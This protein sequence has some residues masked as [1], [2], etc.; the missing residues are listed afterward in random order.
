MRACARRE[1]PRVPIERTGGRGLVRRPIELY[2]PR[3]RITENSQRTWMSSTGNTLLM[4]ISTRAIGAT[5]CLTTLCMA[6]TGSAPTYTLIVGPRTQLGPLAGVP[7]NLRYTPISG[8][9]GDLNADGA[10]DIILGINGAPPAVYFNNRT[11]DP[12]QNVS[13]VFAAPPPGASQAGISWGAVVIAD[14]NGD[15]RPDLAIGG[16]NAPNMI[17]LNDGTATPFNGVSGIAIGTQD[18]SWIPALAD[19]NGD[20]FLD[21]AVANTNHTPSRLY[22]TQGAPLTSGTYATVQV[23]SDVGYGQDTRIADVNGDGK[24][25][26]ILTYTTPSA[27]T[28]PSGV[29]IYLNNGTSDP[30]GNV[31]P[32]RLLLGQSVY[33]VAIADLDHD[34]RPD[35][36][37][38]ISDGAV[39]TQAVDVFLNTGSSSQPFSS[40]QTLQPDEHTGG[41][42]LA[43]AAGDVNG[44]SRPDLL[45]SCLAPAG[46][47]A[48]AP[49]PTNPAVG[50][51]YLNNGTAN[52]FADVAPVDIP[53]AQSSGFGRSVAVDALVANGRPEVLIVDDEWAHHY[54]TVL[55]EDPVAHSDSAS[56]ALDTAIAIAVLA[57]DSA[58]TG[59][60]LD[61]GSVTITTGPR[62]GTVSV[63]SSNGSVT[64]QPAIGYSGADGFEYTV[65]DGLGARSSAAAVSI[66][67]QPAPVA[68]DDLMTLTANESVILSVLS[69]DTSNGGTLDAASIHI[70]AAPIHG[71]A[72]ITNG[73]VVYT[74]AQGYAGVDAFQYSVKDN[75]GTASNV[76][77]V[78]LSV[79]PPPVASNDTASLQANQSAT[80]DVLAND[81]SA[82]GTLDAASISIAAPPA[83][84]TAT[85]AN[86]EIVYAP[87]AGYSG[88]DSFQ[89]SVKDNLGAP[90]N[91]AT[92]SI[93]I[94]ATSNTASGGGSGG[95]GGGSMRLLDLVALAVFLLVRP[96]RRAGFRGSA[97][98]S[99][100]T[101]PVESRA[102]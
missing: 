83:H 61:P 35:L 26:L 39:S 24:P 65:R 82:G 19:V 16:F 21:L 41:G 80:V 45:V 51:A 5:L 22:L 74:P 70:D 42:C 17:Y 97:G 59:Q 18:V 95:G 20:G 94:A 77:T 6:A 11:A 53:A 36:A 63:S 88:S 13:G 87:A 27:P 32:L 25:D 43:V 73:Q 57:N 30:F 12:F 93:D 14:A 56:G 29:A 66:T 68:A 44:D 84:G 86:G 79:Q 46:N 34:G 37:A 40:S 52:P 99:S 69:N 31:T 55:D 100:R 49:T 76:A 7:A 90:S 92:V 2:S 48:P 71:T 91:V 75:F 67:V 1:A 89:Y 98:S 28:D 33:S 8:T 50:A 38:T 81:E 60:T 15:G 102:G 10:P 101:R 78:S 58:G 23:G 4:M 3:P 54:P 72:V 96:F 85:V 64:Y 62:H 47:A 9:I